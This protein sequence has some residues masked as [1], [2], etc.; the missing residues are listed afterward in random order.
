VIRRLP[1]LLL[2]GLLAAAPLAAQETDP[3]AVQPERP[4]VA[5]HAGTVAPGWIELETGVEFDHAVNAWS[6]VT[7]TV[8]K[9]GIA[10][11]VQFSIFGGLTRPAGDNLGVG[12][13]AAGV[14]FRLA[15]GLP[16]LGDFALLPAL[17]LPVGDA[18]HGTGTTDLSLLAISSHQLGT[19]SMDVNVGYTRR[20]GDGTAAPRTAWLWAVA[21]GAPVRGGLG[22]T[23]EI[24][25]YPRTT[26]PAGANG[27]MALLGGPVFT[28][29]PWWTL[30]FGGILK[31]R[32]P[33]SDGI[34]AGG[35]YNIGRLW[36]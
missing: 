9:I 35:V 13:L 21:A 7:P 2:T 18:T 34:Y 1:G 4:T 20:S 27:T 16:V 22:V 12:D 32:G 6:M 15:E 23:A 10:P 14:K 5:T 26:G 36:R 19:V 11:Q 24:F 17:K 30:D 29:H 33:Q 31:L 28:L 3:H 8:I 25:G